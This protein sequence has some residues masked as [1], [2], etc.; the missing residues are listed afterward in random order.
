MLLLYTVR[1][2]AKRIIYKILKYWFN[3]LKIRRRGVESMDILWIIYM[4]LG[5]WAAGR[6]IYRNKILIGTGTA[7]I[8]RKL[9]TGFLLGF[10]LIPIGI[11]GL[12]LEKR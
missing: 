9:V 4:I 1:V 11:I 7:I 12:L 3:G 8:S 2:C 10:I 6:T 5:Y